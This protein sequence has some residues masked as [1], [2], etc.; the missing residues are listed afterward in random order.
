M[1]FVLRQS[2]TIRED[3]TESHGSLNHRAGTC[4]W[5]LLNLVSIIAESLAEPP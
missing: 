4:E 2:Q 3:G 1:S 5:L